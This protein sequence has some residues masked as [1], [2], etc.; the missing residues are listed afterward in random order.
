MYFSYSVESFH[1]FVYYL[2][3]HPLIYYCK[4]LDQCPIFLKNYHSLLLFLCTGQIVGIF[5]FRARA[6]DSGMGL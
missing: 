3:F 2:D 4:D 6:I 1:P 5:H